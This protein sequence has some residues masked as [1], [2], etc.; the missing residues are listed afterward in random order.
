[1]RHMRR[2]RTMRTA[3]PTVSLVIPAYNEES[4]LAGCLEAI[5]LQTVQ[6]L[7]VIVVDNNSTDQTAAIAKRY[8]FVTLVHEPEQ[9]VVYARNKGFSLAR[10]DIIGR[11]D[12]DGQLAPDWIARV[13]SIFTDAS[14][15]AVSGAVGYRD[16]GL[17][18]VFDTV[19]IHIRHYLA[20]RTGAVNELFLYGVNMA[21]RRTAWD[22]VRT[23]VCHHRHMHEDMDLA[24]HM[25][26]LRRNVVFEPDLFATISPR[27]AASSPREFY[28]YVWSNP[29]VYSKHG[30]RSHRYM[31]F[32]AAFV[33]VFYVLIH[34]MYKGYNPRT[35]RFSLV[36]LWHSEATIR[37]SPVSDLL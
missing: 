19:D 27:Q 5:A 34:V 31:Y 4:H 16:V 29:K 23:E 2:L 6:P 14:V 22:V 9:G 37:A 15:D 3:R 17:K 26:Q 21:I 33:S 10:G 11:T 18:K 30:M 28:R 36:R 12:A 13:Q 8:P 25:A 35:Q 7:E 1:M 32:V 24:A 20:A